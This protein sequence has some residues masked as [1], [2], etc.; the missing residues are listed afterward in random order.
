MYSRSRSVLA[1]A[2]LAFST[3]AEPSF[4]PRAFGGAASGLPSQAI[5]MPQ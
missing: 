3:A 5:A 1:P 4:M 2:A